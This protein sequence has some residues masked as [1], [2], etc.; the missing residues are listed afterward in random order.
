MMQIVCCTLYVNNAMDLLD[1]GARNTADRDAIRAKNQWN[2][3]SILLN[4]TSSTPEGQD[5]CT[6]TL[7]PNHYTEQPRASATTEAANS[8]GHRRI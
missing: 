3:D 7:P 4:D 8:A 5:A 1:L 2:I 6:L